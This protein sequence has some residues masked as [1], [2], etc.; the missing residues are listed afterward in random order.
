MKTLLVLVTI[1][2]VF[3]VMLAWCDQNVNAQVRC[4]TAV[5]VDQNTGRITTCF[6]CTDARGNPATVSCN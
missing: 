5:A 6:I 2:F 3:G 4:W 1:A